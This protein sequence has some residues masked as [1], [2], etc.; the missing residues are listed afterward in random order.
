MK[1]LISIDEYSGFLNKL[2][3]DIDIPPHK[4]KDAVDRYQVV[5]KWLEG[6]IYPGAYNGSLD[7]Y[8]QGSFRLGTVTRPVRNGMDSDYD[9]DL[10][11]EIPLPK[12]RTD[13]RSVKKMVGA[14]L[15]ENKVYRDMIDEEGKRCWTLVYS[16]K[17][18]IGFHLDILPAVPDPQTDR[19][20]AIAIT[21]KRDSSYDWSSSDP[22][23]YG[24][25]FDGINRTAFGLVAD[26]Q[27]K[28]VQEKAPLVYA[29][30]G[31]V[32]NQL[33][34]TPL[35]RAIQI[36]KRHRDIKYGDSAYAPIS[37]IIT[38]LSALFYRNEPDLYSALKNIVDR[39]AAHAVLF[40]DPASDF[41]GPITRTPDGVWHI[42]NPVNPKENFADRWHEDGNAR[43][44]MF[45][46]WLTSLRRDLVDILDQ[47][48]SVAKR[49]AIG[50]LGVRPVAT[51]VHEKPKP[52]REF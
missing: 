40:D 45:F 1:M 43:A 28:L 3:E 42:G 7:I 11:C 39:L 12:N 13:P 9:I 26:E 34:R 21:N 51:K 22:K 33:V 2:A 31:D 5:G 29:R 10:V 18:Y 48:P 24:L 27:K 19:N 44:E 16:E 32:P 20:T 37:I 17:D 35:Q 47:D 36:M 23:G 15:K 8:P 41:S 30:V 49:S 6:G 14:R 50:A 4:Y 38:T 52:W 46:S 25:W